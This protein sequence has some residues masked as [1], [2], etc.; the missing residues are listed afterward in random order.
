M[1]F[2]ISSLCVWGFLVLQSPLTLAPL[3]AQELSEDW[4]SAVREIVYPCRADGSDQPALFYDS[5][6]QA[7]KPLLVALHTWS[8]GYKQDMSIPY[9]EWCIEKDWVCIHPNFRG[10][11]R[12]PEAAGSELVVQDILD[13][14]EWARDNVRVDPNRIYLIGVSGGGH[15]SLLMAGRAPHL[16]A[17]VSA[18]VPVTDL[19]R[20]HRECVQAGRRYAVDIEAS[21]GGDP[22]VDA[23]A[24]EEC[25]KR[26]PVTYLENAR[27]IPLDINA[28]ILDG[29]SGSVP[30]GHSIRAFNAA[31]DEKDRLPEEWIEQVEK[32]PQIPEADAFEG[33]DPLYG[34]NPV[35]FRRES[36]TVRL[37]L[38]E[39]GHEILYDA[40]LHWLERQ[41]RP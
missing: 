1:H 35:L 36:G 3:W 23:A 25:R 11:N 32:N 13:S 26:S 5:G 10:P 39:G 34:E 19:E 33:T 7:T 8:G 21:V 41:T 22:S 12:T 4:P 29:H 37:T 6:S 20:W 31:A 2:Y 28:G 17:G 18:W 9:F 30:I 38:F 15:A 24:R 27:N 40:A 14:V 16:W